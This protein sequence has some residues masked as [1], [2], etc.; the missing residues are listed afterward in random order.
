MRPDRPI[1]VLLAGL[2]L[3]GAAYA[4]GGGDQTVQKQFAL[5]AD[6]IRPLATNRG[7]AIASDRITVDGRPV[8]YMY[9]LAPHN[10]MDSGWFFL[11]G[12]EDQAYMDNTANHAVYD[13]NTIA[14][15]DPEIIP[16]LD[17]PI[18]SAFIRA[19]GRLVRD[20]EG[21]PPIRP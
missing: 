18:G 6:Q 14:N 20:P 19:N 11:A 5:R 7:G 3:S 21:A 8:G 10:P 2:A 4:T 12:D 15:Y 1:V 16:L 17:A 9:R 13:V